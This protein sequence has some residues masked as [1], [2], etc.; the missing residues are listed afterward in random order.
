MRAGELDQVVT[1]Y[2]RTQGQDSAGGITNSYSSV[3]TFPAKV[4]TQKGQAALVAASTDVGRSIRVQL[5]YADDVELGQFV[6]WDSQKYFIVECDRSNR[7]KG[8]L[9]VS[10]TAREAT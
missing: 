6:E 1:I 7:R 5:R 4:I 2:S 8:E 3:G 9:W 10:A